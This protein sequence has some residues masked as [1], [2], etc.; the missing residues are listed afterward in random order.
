MATEEQIHAALIKRISN[1]LKKLRLKKNLTQEDMQDFGFNYR[2]YQRLERGKDAMNTRTIS[3]LAKAFKV[4][5]SELLK[6]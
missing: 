2:H 1:N 3:R 5:P 4:D 6:K